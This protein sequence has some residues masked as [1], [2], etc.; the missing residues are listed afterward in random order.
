[1]ENKKGLTLTDKISY[2]LLV[3]GISIFVTG[4]GLIRNP[5][6]DSFFLIDLGRYIVNNRALPK[7]AYWL[8]TD[9]VPTIVQQ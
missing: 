9:D 2:A 8:I 3:I 7:T 4:E 1:M 6:H 5:D